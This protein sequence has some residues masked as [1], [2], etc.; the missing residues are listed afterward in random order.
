MTEDGFDQSVHLQ[1]WRA[2]L[3]AESSLA[4]RLERELV[5][6]EGLPLAWYEVLLVL[7]RAP[8]GA[9]RLQQLMGAVLMTK[10]GVTRLV[11]RME[12]AG[13]VSRAGC[14]SDRRGA[15]AVITDLGRDKLRRASPV[16]ADGIQRHLASVLDLSRAAQ[17]RD[18]LTAVADAL[19]GSGPE[20]PCLPAEPGGVVPTMT[21][22]GNSD[23]DR[24]ADPVG[25]G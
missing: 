17:L 1:L 5:A 11:D 23:R 14:P 4:C 20:P 19:G 18:G 25:G 9:V 15:Y 21:A 12:Q 22:R 2:L 16:H 8:R 13:L 7:D 3:R 24:L 10:S 6:A